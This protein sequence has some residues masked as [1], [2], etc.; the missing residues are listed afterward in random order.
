MHMI[1]CSDL[2]EVDE[3]HLWIAQ[4]WIEHVSGQDGRRVPIAMRCG[5]KLAFADHRRGHVCSALCAGSHTVHALTFGF[6]CSA[7]SQPRLL[8]S[9]LFGEGL[10]RMCVIS[11][12]MRV[13]PLSLVDPLS[14]SPTCISVGVAVSHHIMHAVSVSHRAPSTCPAV[15]AAVRGTGKLASAH[16][17]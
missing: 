3:L 8:S 16:M 14:S 5:L 13:D 6:E 7:P 1:L 15:S 2:H 4:A 9:A 11:S 12:G 17:L 10:R